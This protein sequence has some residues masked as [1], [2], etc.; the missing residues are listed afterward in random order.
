MIS[1][2]PKVI[3]SLHLIFLSADACYH[4]EAAQLK[5]DKEKGDLRVQYR[6]S[7][8]KADIPCKLNK[9]AIMSK[10]KKFL[11]YI[12]ELKSKSAFKKYMLS[13]NLF[14]SYYNE[15]HD[16]LE[17][18]IAELAKILESLN[19]NLHE[20]FFLITTLVQLS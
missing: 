11:Q 13:I 19:L 9:T 18:R 4:E 3:C 5:Q 16:L 10:T 6:E 2:V 1:L 17:K 7:L 14:T 20:K 12:R 15:T 8:D